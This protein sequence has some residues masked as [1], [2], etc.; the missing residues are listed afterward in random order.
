MKGE[1]FDEDARYLNLATFRRNGLAVRTPVWFARVGEALYAYS[2]ADAGKV[3][4]VR[5]SCK[6]EVA[7]CNVRGRPFGG[8]LTARA[9][10]V[11]DDR[12][13]A[14]A[15]AALRARYG[16]SMRMADLVARLSRRF[17]R[18]AVIRIEVALRSAGA[19]SD[20]QTT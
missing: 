10:L 14:M 8:W 7:P 19:A 11:D 20:R 5:I 4:R 9:F 13:A 18:R 12:E 1:A 6:A 17:E 3:K 2:A 15:F 16:L